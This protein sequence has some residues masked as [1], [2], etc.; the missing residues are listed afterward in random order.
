MDMMDEYGPL[1][2][3]I[4]DILTAMCHDRHPHNRVDPLGSPA[5]GVRLRNQRDRR[6][7]RTDNS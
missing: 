5:G 3:I 2:D 1:E 4:S 7:S 6:I